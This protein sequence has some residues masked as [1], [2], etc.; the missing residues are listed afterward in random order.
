[1][2]YLPNVV[3]VSYYF[4]KRRALATGIAVCGAG[5]GCFVFAP[6]GQWLLRT[7]AWKNAMLLVAGVTLH[8]CVFGALLRNLEPV[9]RRRKPR[10]KNIFDR[11]KEEISAK[12]RRRKISE[13]GPVQ[14]DIKQVHG[15][16]HSYLLIIQMQLFT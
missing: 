16:F 7:Y 15:G 12:T 1:M 5:V 6:V 14:E 8:G 10:A 2:L 4:H 9:H 13:V 3:A 11:L